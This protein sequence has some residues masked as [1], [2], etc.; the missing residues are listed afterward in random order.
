RALLDGLSD[1]VLA[2]DLEGRIIYVN[3]AA[4]ALLDR[5]A[6][7]LVGTPVIELFP[8]RLQ[9]WL[10]TDFAAFVAN[11]LPDLAGRA[12]EGVL[13]RRTGAELPVEVVVDETPTGYGESVVVGI[14]RQRRADRLTRWSDLTRRLF[15]TLAE[16]GTGAPAEERLVEALGSELGWEGTALWSLDPGGE[17]LRRALWS[18]PAADPEG[19]LLGARPP[20]ASGGATLPLHALDSGEP[21]WISDLRLD[22]RFSSGPAASTGV[23]SVV[24]FPV[25]YGGAVVGVVELMSTRVRDLDPELVE[26]VDAVSGPVG[27]LLVALQRADEREHLVAELDRARRE[28]AFLLDAS[29]VLAEASDYHD[30]L[31]RLAKVAVPALG[32][33]CIIDVLDENGRLRRLACQHHDPSVEHL[34]AELHHDFPPDPSGQHPSV[35]VVRHNR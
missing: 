9:S 27:Q 32:D 35:D 31:E 5:P 14:V 20:R 11:R 19:R 25:R 10:G 2:T 4:E 15:D 1:G 8:P 34:V 24:V 33:L 3:A 17:L 29:R 28:Q 23:R 30:T 6:G 16:A 21:F 26:L 12:H 7:E 13:V 22:P 18:D